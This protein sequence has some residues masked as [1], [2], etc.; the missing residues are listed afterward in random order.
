MRAR[1]VAGVVLLGVAGLAAAAAALY[2]HR[3]GPAGAGGAA[4]PPPPAAGRSLSVAEFCSSCHQLPDP[5]IL[6]RDRWKSKVELMYALVGATKDKPPK[7]LPPLAEAIEHFASRAPEKLPPLPTT[8]DAGPGPLQ[9]DR[10]PLKMQDQ[11][12]FPGT[13]NVHFVHL[14]DDTRFDLLVCEMRF[15]MVL[16]LQPYES[17]GVIHRLGQVPHPC[18]AEVV[19]LDRDGRRDVLVANLGTV[20]PSDATDGSVVWLR[21][22]PEGRFEPVALASGLGR[23]ADAEAADFDGDGDLDVIAAVFGWRAVGEVLYLENRTADWESPRFEPRV[24]DPR[25]G[26]IHVP[27]ADLNGDGRPD[28]VALI[29]QHHETVVAFLNGGGAVFEPRVIFSAPHPNWGCSGI[30]LAD[31]DRDGDLDVLLANGDTLDDLILKPYHGVAWL[32]NRGAYP[33]TYRQLTNLYGA[34]RAKP[35]DLDGDGDLD[36]V[37]PAFLPFLKPEMPGVEL[38]DSIIWLEQTSPGAFARHSLEAAS[39]FHPTLDAADFDGDGRVD[40]VV[41]N[42]TMAKGAQDTLEHSMV[43]LKNKK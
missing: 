9:L 31:L 7:G 23:V 5:G 40:I 42:M 34:H 21:R 6:P 11:P 2:G 36:L 25:P 22:R 15:G 39:C 26:S 20:T 37:V 28:F 32:E 43:L 38:A 13:A 3:R 10:L 4:Q 41:G 14:Y 18:H 17:L 29:S 19:D 30:D 12:P 8:V 35:A 1:I 24:I 27:V 33:Y 16:A